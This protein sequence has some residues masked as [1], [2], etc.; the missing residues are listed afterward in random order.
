MG[1][2]P[3]PVAIITL[4][5]MTTR[6]IND[7]DVV[8]ARDVDENVDVGVH[9]GQPLRLVRSALVLAWPACLPGINFQI[10]FAVEL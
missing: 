4:S 5:M 10:E 3:L 2:L 7:D 6:T 9:L 8:A 1:L